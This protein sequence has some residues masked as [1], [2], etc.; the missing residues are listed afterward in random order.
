MVRKRPTIAD[1]RANKGKYQYSMLRVETLDEL[2][3]AEAA[4]IDMCSV[5]PEMLTD[6]DARQIAPSVFLQPGLNFYEIGTAD[7]FLRFAFKMLKHGADAIYCS[8]GY[9]TLKRLADDN[10]PVIGHVGLCPSRCTWTGGFRA[11]GKT[12]ESA[13]G[14]WDAVKRLEDVGAVGAEMEV[15]PPEVAA[16]ISK[17]TPLF[18]ISMGSGTGCDA[19]YLFTDDL[20]GQNRGHVP[21]HARKY[22][23][24]AKEFDRLQAERIAAF[25][26]YHA[27]VQ[28]GAFPKASEV[29]PV[30]AAELK[31]LISL[32][33]KA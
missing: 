4:G 28:S 10:V 25:K 9:P 19:Q 33:P 27:D 17:R 6:T 7:D 16:E 8:A 11:V 1:L 26:E 23:D 21:R 15:V 13:M 5:P 12:A 31:K 29:V 30:E 3:A 22:R 32:L 2:A 14:I 18:M 24:F 20:L